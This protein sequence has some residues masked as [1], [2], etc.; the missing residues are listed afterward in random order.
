MQLCHREWVRGWGGGGGGPGVGVA[1]TDPVGKKKSVA[2][3]FC[4]CMGRDG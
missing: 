1:D 4:K 3:R 2:E